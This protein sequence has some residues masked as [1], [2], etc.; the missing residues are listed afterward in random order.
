MVDEGC[1]EGVD[2]V[3]GFHNIPNFDEGDIRVCTGAFFASATVVK[4]KIIG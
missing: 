1:M 3:Y 4:I 2:E